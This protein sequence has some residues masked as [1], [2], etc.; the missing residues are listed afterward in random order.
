MLFISIKKP[1]KEVSSQT[2]SRWIKKTL[3]DS[4][5]D[6]TTFDA[7]STRHASTSSAKRNGISIDVIKKAAGW[8]ESS[9][10]FA[11]FY[12]RSL[13]KDKTLFAK[14]VLSGASQ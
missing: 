8:T 13:V 14:S 9:K 1:H 3:S 4:G 7:Y 12:N 6:T 10:T 2:L 5:I 11:L